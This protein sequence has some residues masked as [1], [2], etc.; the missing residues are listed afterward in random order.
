MKTG[1]F[2]RARQAEGLSDRDILPLVHREFP[3]AKTSLNSIIRIS[4]N[5]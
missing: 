4:G 5:F 3:G 1:Q 2:I